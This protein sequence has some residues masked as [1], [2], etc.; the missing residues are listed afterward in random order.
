MISSQTELFGELYGTTAMRAVFSVRRRL[1]A[2]LEVEA[3]LARAQGKLGVIPVEAAKAIDAAA[4]VEQIDVD[5]IVA[6]SQ[7][8]GYP[9]VALTRQLAQLAGDAGG[10]VHWGATTQDILDTATV[11][12]LEE[13]FALLE[14]ELTGIVEALAE[15]AQ[16]ERDTVMAGRTH[17][18][19]ALPVTFGYVVATWLAPLVEHLRDLRAMRERLRVLQ[20]GGAVGTLASLGAR[21]R[22]VALALGAELGLRVPDAPW[23]A[24]RSGFAQACAFVGVVCGSVAKMA[25]DVMLLMQTEVAEV[26]EPHE[27]GR[28]GSST[29]PHKRNPIASEY[30]LATARAV[31]A[32]V[33]LML[34]AMAGDHQRSTGP[35]QS[36]EL[37]LPPIFIYASGAL[38]HGRTIARG[39][40]VDRERM[41]A[42]L[43]ATGGLI[44]SE[45]VAMALAGKVGKA[46]AHHLVEQG[47]ST[48]LGE[49]R[50][51][52]DVLA[53]DAAIAE[54]FDRAALARLL[55]PSGY[56]GEAG[57]VVDRV[58]RAANGVLH[59][60][61]ED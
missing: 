47:V 10:Y 11:L 7:T 39:M 22:E 29:M 12:Q 58:V 38:A 28:G 8:V 36:E 21:G 32:L 16:A 57:A 26:F 42:N 37:A 48:A 50:G 20:F 59:P 6:S 33:P 52:A 53:A 4:D 17:L 61:K 49:K 45:A 5:A 15:R 44:A 60:T 43:A 24:D 35:W 13:A 25:T 19:H 41:R 34:G 40:T 3:A 56:V 30:V 23:H 14:R 9:V 55:D 54:H 18:Q 31:D 2:M 51:L 1:D 27:P 46:R